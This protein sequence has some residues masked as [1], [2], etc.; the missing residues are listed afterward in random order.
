[1]FERLLNCRPCVAQESLILLSGEDII[2]VEHQNKLAVQIF[3]VTGV[4][5]TEL[6]WL[7]KWIF[8]RHA[9]IVRHRSLRLA[10]TELQRLG[11]LCL[12]IPEIFVGQVLGNGVSK[13]AKF[14]FIKLRPELG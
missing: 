12:P 14:L 4:L 5:P 8:L 1:M 3:P 13:L 7:H 2:A 6:V 10:H 9:E 11:M